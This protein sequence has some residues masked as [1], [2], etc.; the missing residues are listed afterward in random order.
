MMLLGHGSTYIKDVMT[1]HL[2][3]RKVKVHTNG[4]KWMNGNIRKEMNRRY[5]LP[6]TAQSN[7]SDADA[8][9]LY[10]Q[11]RNHVAKIMRAAEAEYWT[12]KFRNANSSSDV[13]RVVGEMQGK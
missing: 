4:L 10:R 9:K 7:P 8:W 1:D 13:W 6:K 2:K 3:T 5:A 12:D 11:Q